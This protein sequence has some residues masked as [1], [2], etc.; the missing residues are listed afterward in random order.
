[1]KRIDILIIDDDSDDVQFF[2]QVLNNS[3]LEAVMIAF[4]DADAALV[5]LQRRV[6]QLEKL[7]DVIIMDL[8]L[9]RVQ[10]HDALAMLKANE[11]FHKIPVIVLSASKRAEDNDKSFRFGAAGYFIKPMKDEE[12]TPILKLMKTLTHKDERNEVM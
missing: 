1:M 8:N 5:H 6:E 4:F 10:G 11:R 12:W 9:P 7:P 2:Q 3:D